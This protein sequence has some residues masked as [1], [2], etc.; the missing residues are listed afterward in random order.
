MKVAAA[1]AEAKQHACD[2]ESEEA[3]RNLHRRLLQQK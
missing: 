1:A 2:P 3:A